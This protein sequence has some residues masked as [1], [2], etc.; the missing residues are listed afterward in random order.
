M[1][2]YTSVSLL[3]RFSILYFTLGFSIFLASYGQIY[4][5]SCMFTITHILKSF[6]SPYI[7]SPLSSLF[8][9]IPLLNAVFLFLRLYSSKLSLSVSHTLCFLSVFRSFSFLVDF[10]KS[11]SLAHYYSFPYLFTPWNLVL[12]VP[13]LSMQTLVAFVMFFLPQPLCSCEM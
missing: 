1:P 5:H 3:H 9:F 10:Y 11:I 13:M 12:V 8:D 4:S 7:L 6:L 2:L